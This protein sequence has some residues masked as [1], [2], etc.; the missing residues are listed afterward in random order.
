ME[1][2]K[3]GQVISP[4][5]SATTPSPE[6]VVPAGA[7]EPERPSEQPAAPSPNPLPES[8]D[9]EPATADV[10]WQF[11]AGA[12][13]ST[14]PGASGFNTS[15]AP[16]QANEDTIDW[17]AAEFIDH[18]K[19]SSWYGTLALVALVAAILAYLLTKD[20]LTTAIVILAA[21][22][23]GVS[24][25]R[26]PQAQHYSL[27]PEGVLVGSKAY[28]YHD[29]KTFSIA[30][31]GANTIV[32]FMPLKRFMPP[33]TIYVLPELEDKVTDFLASYLPF[34]EHKTDAVDNLMRR[35][36]F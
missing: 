4:Q 3:P 15:P 26:K 36:R 2:F 13:E 28:Y 22:L 9:P 10:G 19:T 31:E 21:I 5:D 34:A 27:A 12:A 18:E 33:L 14:Y 20:K 17:T 25:A 16:S 6:P 23:L 35:I 30:K 7:P 1:E 8:T 24:A 32:V 29:F 11:K